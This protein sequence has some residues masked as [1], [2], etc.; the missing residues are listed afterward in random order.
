M[1]DCVVEG[2]TPALPDA[3]PAVTAA[4]PSRRDGRLVR[5]ELQQRADDIQRRTAASREGMAAAASQQQAVQADLEQLDRVRGDGGAGRCW[6]LAR[7]RS[8]GVFT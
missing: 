5:L 4:L 3:N 2:C 7:S 6:T 8:Q 1:C